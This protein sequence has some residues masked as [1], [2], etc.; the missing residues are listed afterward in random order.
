M[1]E[2]FDGDFDDEDWDH[3]LGG[4]HVV[5]SSG[6]E[7]VAHVAVV[8]RLL[9]VGERPFRSGY[10]EAVGTAPGRHG[11]GVG[12]RAMVEAAGVVRSRFELGTLATGRWSFY[13]RLGWERWTGPTFVRDGDE[14]TRTEDDDDAV[15]VLRFGPSASIDL[16][17]PLTCEARPG[18][19]W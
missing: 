2:A 6:T 4:W 9:Q 5:V 3:A 12:S 7:V 11:Q 14:V 16:T 8:P 17:S 13:E 15:M 10:V 1:D 19:V 18:D